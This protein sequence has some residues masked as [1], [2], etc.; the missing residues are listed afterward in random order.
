MGRLGVLFRSFK[1]AVICLWTPELLLVFF[2]PLKICV[3]TSVRPA[4]L[5]C[6]IGE[7]TLL[8]LKVLL[9]QGWSKWNAQTLG[10]EKENGVKLSEMHIRTLG[11]WEEIRM[12]LSHHCILID[13]FVYQ[14][15]VSCLAVKSVLRNHVVILSYYSWGIRSF[16]PII[17]G[18]F[19]RNE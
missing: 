10:R 18:W 1:Y 13:M 4:Y 9:K 17:F 14:H 8:S 15:A 3:E 11:R 19:K 7:W 16:P 12:I 5:C 6:T 2:F